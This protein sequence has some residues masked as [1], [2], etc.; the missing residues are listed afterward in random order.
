[1]G[2]RTESG[3]IRGLKWGRNPLAL[4]IAA[5]LAASPVWAK[6]QQ[7]ES[8]LQTIEVNAKQSEDVYGGDD[9]GY[10]G[11]RSL[12]ATK[13][14][15]PVSETPRSVSIVTREQMDD[16]AA[17]SISDA[18]RY[19]PGMQ[20]GFYGEDNKQDW[21]IV[22]G[23]KQANNGLYRDGT[24]T[25]SDGFYSWQLDPANLERVEI[26]R[27][28]ASVLYGQ[29]PPGGVINVISKRPKDYSFGSVTAEYGTWDRK[30]LTVDV[31][32][33]IGDGHAFRVVA[34][35]RENGTQVDDLEA[36]RTLFAPSLKLNLGEATDLTL[37]ATYQKDDSDPYLQFLPS[38]GTLTANKNGY[39]QDDVAVGNPDYEYFKR[40]QYIFGYQLEH[41]INDSTRFDQSVRYG[42]IDID[43]KQMYS[44]GYVRDLSPAA[45]PAAGQILDPTNARRDIY[46]G[47]STEDGSAS[48]W[49]ADN[50]LT[51]KWTFN[52]IEHTL[53]AGVDYQNLSIES[54]DFANDPL[55]AD[56][57][58]LNGLGTPD[59]NFDIYSPSYTNNV[60][61]FDINTFSVVDDSD[62]QKET[63]DSYQ[64]GGYL[65]DQMKIGENLV[66][67][68]GG[69]FDKTRTEFDNKAT[70]VERK[71]DNEEWTA[72]TGAAWLFGNGVTAYASYAQ[73]FQPILQLDD[74]NNPAKPEQG[75]QF[76]VGMKYQPEGFDG[77][78]NV[79][80]FDIT[81][82]NLSRRDPAT[83]DFKQ[84]GEVENQGVELEFVS[85]ITTSFSLIANASFMDPEIKNDVRGSA[86]EGNRPNQVADTT[87]SVWGKYAFLQGPLGGFSVGTGLSYT[88]E[89]FGDDTETLEVPSYTLWDATVSYRWQ[90]F[91]FQVAAKNLADKE[92]VATC[93]YY[94][95][96]GNGRNVIGSVTYAW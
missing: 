33:P 35:G 71:I 84:I 85:N 9:F 16:R 26:L 15:T 14:D 1:M 91:K 87:A 96:Y 6:E 25:Y 55:V 5:T 64:V 45:L 57:N 28:P 12:T 23:F 65:Q 88:G 22:R 29:T 66:V 61:L 58:T 38:E 19:T 56:G 47:I 52:N 68:L 78:F 46:R 69:R 44:L 54:K 41:E 40:T 53:L 37:L 11:Q 51:H 62:R 77:Y 63:T 74:D 50:R 24:R 42:H 10:V 75:D 86:V 30:Q 94:C 17:V 59:I 43:L 92:Y 2:N 93:N 95:W 27:G 89:T 32:A 18:L 80:V 4:A 60:V 31:G 83:Q 67:M 39:I 81:Q 76:E 34:L 48:T 7:D 79:A 82:E 21:F 90:D 20:A 70:N 13:T 3:L 72:N 49:T 8:E 73:F 36:K